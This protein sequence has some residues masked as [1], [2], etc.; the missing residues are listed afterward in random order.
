MSATVEQLP[1]LPRSGALLARAVLPGRRRPGPDAGLPDRVVVV[2]RHEQDPTRLAEYCRVTG[3]RLRDAVPATW[4]HVLTF[5]LHL[6]VMGQPDFPFPLAGVLHA[7]N[8]M[9]LHRVVTVAEPLR[10]EVTARD[11]APHKRGAT[12]D[13]VGRISV[14]DELVWEGRSVYLAIGRSVPPGPGTRPPRPEAPTAVASQLWRLPADLGRRYA[15]VSGDH[16]PIHLRRL[17]A[18][19]FGFKQP[20]IHGMWT[21][22]KALSA[23]GP[24]LPEAFTAKVTFTKPIPLPNSV[25]FAVEPDRD[26]IRFAVVNAERTYLVGEVARL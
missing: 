26:V 23:L 21:H 12:F 17:T 7:S 16:N 24:L 6:F 11:L 1:D 3:F 4:L 10:I 14:G 9:T 18:L 22:A 25:G 2:P 19:P 8:E 20:I 13:M 15:K 5:P